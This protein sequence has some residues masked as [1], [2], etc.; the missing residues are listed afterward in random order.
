[1]IWQRIMPAEMRVVAAEPVVPIVAHSALLRSAA[2]RLDFAG[3]RLD[4]KVPVAERE[5]RAVET[6]DV[7]AKQ[8][9]RA[10]NPAVQPVFE[11]IDAGLEVLG[12]EAAIELLD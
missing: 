6:R 5:R 7:A 12:A 3:V 2:R 4:A 8:A 1:M 9:A 10:V 11:A